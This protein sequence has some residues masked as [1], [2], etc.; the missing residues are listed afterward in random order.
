MNTWI[1]LLLADLNACVGNEMAEDVFNWYDV[2]GRM[3]EDGSGKTMEELCIE[4]WRT[5]WFCVKEC[6]NT[7]TGC[8]F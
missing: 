7:V 6:N 8:E 2:P 3:E 1:I 4:Q 5:M